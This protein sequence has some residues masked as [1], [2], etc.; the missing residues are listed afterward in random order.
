MISTSIELVQRTLGMRPLEGESSKTTGLVREGDSVMWWGW[1]LGM[2]QL[3]ESLI[4]LYQRP[5]FFQDTMGRGRFRKFQHDH[6]FVE[7]GGHTLITD[8]IR[9]S[10][11]MGIA[12]DVVGHYVMVPYIARQLRKRMR[13]LKKVAE[14]NEWQRYLPKDVD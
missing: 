10:L 14:S 7:I 6:T 11:P 2:P 13:I 12:G 9:F 1:K 3:H 4:T 5:D 8:K